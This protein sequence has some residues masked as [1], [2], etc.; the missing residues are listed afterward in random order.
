MTSRLG[1]GSA[2]NQQWDNIWYTTACEEA[3]SK[4]VG[5]YGVGPF[6]FYNSIF[7]IGDPSWGLFSFPV[8]IF[9][10]P[11]DRQQNLATHL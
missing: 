4:G 6:N 8:P 1:R 10:N 7:A 9:L 2:G 5:R 3:R 11:L